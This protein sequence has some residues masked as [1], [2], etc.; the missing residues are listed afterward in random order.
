MCFINDLK[1]LGS[2][3]VKKKKIEREGHVGIGSVVGKSYTGKEEI[4][5]P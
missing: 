1:W 3:E 4:I 5:M 2:E